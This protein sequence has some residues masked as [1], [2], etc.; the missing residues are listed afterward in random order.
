MQR[1]IP[2][3]GSNG[4]RNPGIHPVIQANLLQILTNPFKPIRWLPMFYS[5]PTITAKQKFELLGQKRADIYAQIRKMERNEPFFRAK[6]I[7]FL[8]ASTLTFELRHPDVQEVITGLVTTLVGEDG[9]W[10]TTTVKKRLFESF[11]GEVLVLSNK[12]IERS[13][14]FGIETSINLHTIGLHQ[15]AVGPWAMPEAKI[16]RVFID[17]LYLHDDS[18]HGGDPVPLVDYA[19]DTTSSFLVFDYAAAKKIPEYYAS[20][21]QM[22]PVRYIRVEEAILTR[23]N[24]EVT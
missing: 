2:L 7:V 14:K 11:F 19:F 8:I 22:Q 21:T 6:D 18:W 20:L 15:G 10:L 12:A 16:E 23:R 5:Q 24:Y 3:N 17:K 13:F 4:E 1:K 9:N